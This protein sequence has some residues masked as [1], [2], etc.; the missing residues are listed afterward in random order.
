MHPDPTVA[1]TGDVLFNELLLLAD[2]HPSLSQPLVRLMVRVTPLLQCSN[3]GQVERVERRVC[4]LTY[5]VLH[6]QK[7]GTREE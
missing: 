7:E 6:R 1:L 2:Q 4:Q 5:L 3:A